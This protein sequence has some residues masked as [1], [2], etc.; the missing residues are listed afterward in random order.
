MKTII[1]EDERNNA[2]LLCHFLTKYCPKV[3]LIDTCY[4]KEEAV[5]TINQ[6]NPELLFLD[7]I[8]EDGTAFDLL[9][10]IDHSQTH[11]IF[12]TA[13]DHYAL[14]AFQ[15]HAVDYLLKPLQIDDLIN[16][17]NKVLNRDGKKELNTP[18]LRDI[19]LSSAK[20]KSSYVT[21]PNIDKVNFIKND[22]IIYCKSSGRYTEFYLNDDR[23]IVASK[24][25]G[26]FEKLLNPN[27]FFRVHK[28]YIINL[29]Y[30]MNI[31]KKAGNYCELKNGLSIPISRRR[32]ENLIQYINTL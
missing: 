31:N 17:V 25:L 28:S 5:H 27:T 16:A 19:L 8:L 22:S 20:D 24:S 29:D 2:D 26:E 7:I 4:N 9:K 13:F 12:I 23:R 14:K 3:E 1:V 6:K 21:V 18:H 30:L 11:I 32:I 10:E 15:Y